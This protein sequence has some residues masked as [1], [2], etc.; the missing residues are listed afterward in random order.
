VNKAN[1][2][3]AL[4]DQRAAVA[5]YDRAIEIR[6]R[7][8]HQEGRR[9]LQG[10]Y[11]WGLVGRAKALLDLG[12]RKRAQTDAR[13]AVAILQQEVTRTGRADLQAVLDWA[14]TALKEV[15]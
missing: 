2:V 11:A 15:L 4:G 1:A 14:T 13:E 10:D 7:L 9:E 12:D 3:S 8:V 6:E 5:L